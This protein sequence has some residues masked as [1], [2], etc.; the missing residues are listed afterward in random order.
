MRYFLL[1]FILLV[2]AVISIAGFRGSQ[3]RQP[4]LEVFPD[5]DRQ[6]KLRPQASDNFFSDGR[7]SRLPVAGT[8]A[9]SSPIQLSSADPSRV[10]YPFEDVPANTGMAT[11]TTNFVETGP[12][13]ITP[14]FMARGRER[15]QIF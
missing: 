6:L 1:G 13:E 14:Q 10:A 9:R 8:I 5:M 15:Y 3:S 4:P 11:G 2:V 12:F 7:S